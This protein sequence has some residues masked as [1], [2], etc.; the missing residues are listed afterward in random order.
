MLLSADVLF[1]KIWQGCSIQFA[2]E[3]LKINPQSDLSGEEFLSASAKFLKKA[4]IW[5][6]VFSTVPVKLIEEDSGQTWQQHLGSH[7][8]AEGHLAKKELDRIEREAAGHSGS[9]RSGVSLA[10]ETPY[11]T[12]I[13]N[14][15]SHASAGQ[16][17]FRLCWM[18]RAVSSLTTAA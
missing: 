15:S 2:R 13:H 1:G 9:R 17:T 5:I 3:A 8:N 4:S 7:E 6:Y 10:K 12:A 14:F 18:V 16:F 11:Q